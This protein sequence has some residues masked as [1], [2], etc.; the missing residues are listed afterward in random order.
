MPN[1]VTY[2]VEW[3]CPG[4]DG[5]ILDVC[6]VG[7]LN[8]TKES[9]L[10]CGH[11]FAELGDFAK[12]PAC[13][14]TRLGAMDTFG[15]DPIPTDLMGAAE[16]WFNI[17]LVRRGVA[18]LN[19]AIVRDR[20]CEPAWRAKYSFLSGLGYAES[21]LKTIEAAT[22]FVV[23]PDLLISYAHL[24]G[25]LKRVDE[26]RDVYNEYLATA[27]AGEFADEARRALRAID[28]GKP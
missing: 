5:H 25:Q 22:E 18:H 15:L 1:Q 2:G 6:P 13:E 12:C 9:C 11:G 8:P 28:G 17:G 7:P 14:M 16:Q 27:P 21:A 4:C 3:R 23:N 20:A 26:A 10:N 24:L 19:L